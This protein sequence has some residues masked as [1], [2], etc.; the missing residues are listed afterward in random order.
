MHSV[1]NIGFINKARGEFTIFVII[2]IRI[3]CFLQKKIK[4][5][6]LDFWYL[7]VY[8]ENTIYTIQTIGKI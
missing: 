1:N 2:A 7:Y 3:K 8:T 5:T 4:K 6:L